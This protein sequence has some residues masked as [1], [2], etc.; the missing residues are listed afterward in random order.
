MDWLNFRL[1]VIWFCATTVVCTL[2][3]LALNNWIFPPMTLP[4]G[5]F[6][7]RRPWWHGWEGTLFTG[8]M[9][10]LMAG[11]LATLR[12]LRKSVLKKED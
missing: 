4:D 11:V 8:A 7:V 6:V 2:G 9:M 3:C 12:P 5:F 1:G 10:G